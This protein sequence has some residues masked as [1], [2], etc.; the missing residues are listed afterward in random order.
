MTKFCLQGSVAHMIKQV[1]KKE[2]ERQDVPPSLIW[3]ERH[4]NFLRFLFVFFY[5]TFGLSEW[6]KAFVS[7]PQLDR[8]PHTRR[9]GSPKSH[10][11]GTFQKSRDGGRL[12][13]TL[14]EERRITALRM[15]HRWRKWLV[16]PSIDSHF[17]PTRWLRNHTLA[18]FGEYWLTRRRCVYAW[19][20][21]EDGNGR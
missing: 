1:V 5:F 17:P 4:S 2:K 13:I 19:N 16:H 3:R 14:A 11:L 9:R 20:A 15:I 10:H 12:Q 21:M 18:C 6:K 8:L 7:H